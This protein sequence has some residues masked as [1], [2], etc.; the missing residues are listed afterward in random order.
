MKLKYQTAKQEH[1]MNIQTDQL[2]NL[3]NSDML[4]NNHRTIL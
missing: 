2:D 4:G 3:S 1:Y